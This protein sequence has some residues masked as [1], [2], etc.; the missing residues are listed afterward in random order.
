VQKISALLAPTESPQPITNT[1]KSYAVPIVAESKDRKRANE[2][3]VK[4]VP[5]KMFKYESPLDFLRSENN[6][7]DE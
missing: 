2:E 4:N 1:L 6:T 5:C 3:N 7:H